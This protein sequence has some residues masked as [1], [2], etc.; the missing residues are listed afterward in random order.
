[1]FQ[2]LNEFII[3]AVAHLIAVISPGPDFALIIRQTVKYNRKVAI[4]SSLGIA[5]GIL[6]HITYCILGFALLLSNNMTIYIIFKMLC[7]SYLLYLGV[8]SLIKNNNINIR[9]DNKSDEINKGLSFFHAYKEG[10]ITNI[11]NVKATFFFLS[12]YSFINIS[13]PK[14]IQLFY[15][16]WMTIITGCWFILIS[17]FFTNNI[18]TKFTEK[19]S[20]NLN[21]AMGIVLIYIAV[22]IFLYY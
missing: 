19:Y 22:K 10:L 12:L 6:F 15:G 9:L 17:I 13:T 5:S 4:F 18:V 2:Y 21:K 3:I 11:F 8:V 16:L 20:D 7:A 1:M 14:L